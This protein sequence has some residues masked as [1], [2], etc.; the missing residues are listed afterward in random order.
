M[1]RFGEFRS[2]LY[3]FKVKQPL[4]DEFSSARLNGK[5]VLSESNFRLAWIAILSYE[6]ACIARQHNVIDLT[7]GVG[8]DRYH[9]ADVRKMV[10]DGFSRRFT[11]FF[12]LFNNRK[13]I[14]ILHIS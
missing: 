6:I 4:M 1:L 13:E 14:A 12:S 3:A 11:R 5:I 9:F 10:G 7:L 2:R 8:A